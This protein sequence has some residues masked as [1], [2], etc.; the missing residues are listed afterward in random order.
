MRIEDY[1]DIWANKLRWELSSVPPHNVAGRIRDFVSRT[2]PGTWTAA[3]KASATAELQTRFAPKGAP[4]HGTNPRTPPN[5][6]LHTSPFRFV[7]IPSNVALA[8]DTAC[9]AP[10]A[11]GPYVHTPDNAKPLKDGYSG[12]LTVRW[13][14]ETPILIGVA[15][16]PG[17]AA[18]DEPMQLGGQYVIPGA[19]LRGMVRSTME[20]V[21]RARLTQVNTHHAY[22]LRDFT[23]SRYRER[24]AASALRAGWLEKTDEGYQLTP[25]DMRIVK[26]RDVLPLLPNWPH[27]AEKIGEQHRLW[28]RSSLRDKYSAAGM[29]AAGAG[30]PTRFACNDFWNDFIDV[31]STDPNALPRVRPLPVGTVAAGAL[32]GTLVFS[33]ALPNFSKTAAVLDQEDLVPTL[34]NAKKYECVFFDG[35]DRVAVPLR[36]ETMSRFEL[37]NC[38]PSRRGRQPAGSYEVLAPTLR[39][40]R[41]IPVFY[42]GDLGGNQHSL[43]IGLT[44]LF[45]IG[46]DYSVGDKLAKEREHAPDPAKPDLVEALFGH[47]FEPFDLGKLPDDAPKGLAR[48]GRIAFGFARLVNPRDSETSATPLNTLMMAP[49]ASFAPFYLKG[50]YK[51]WSDPDARLAGRKRYFPRFA[52]TAIPTASAS[53]ET[54]LRATAQLGNAQ[55]S[56]DTLSRLRLLKPRDARKP[57]I[58]EGTIRLHNVLAK[59]IG[60]LLWVL[61]HGG[62]PAKPYRHMIGRAKPFGAGQT[63]VQSVTLDLVRNDGN[64][65]A[66]VSP[67]AS[68]TAWELPAAG[69]EGWTT[70]GAQSLTPFLRAFE[71]HMKTAAIEPSWPLVIE[72]QELLACS[73][74]GHLSAALPGAPAYPVLGD[75]ATIRKTT[76]HTS[77]EAPPTAS[78]NDRF[79]TIPA[80]APADIRLPYQTPTASGI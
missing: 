19:T 64:A 75:F 31:P 9:I 72:I 16:G 33:D 59:E 8:P 34:G 21:S 77:S 15:D 11:F 20:I 6:A 38:V 79:L 35:D 62:D 5:A 63:R 44:R 80:I 1:A 27:A 48:K 17:A 37:M 28:L 39:A 49:R 76:K 46:H 47:V 2:A 30:G 54:A 53:V 68:E 57:L 60:A 78:V 41:R 74:P 67:T 56:P 70:P 29:I 50:R 73:K 69:S 65:I 42:T 40:Q 25:C 58:F 3:Q 71:Q 51:D 43:E 52:E 7:T 13:A 10:G 12:D 61:T 4:G 23:H 22:P 32:S 66:Q 45:K 36:R 14:V 55:P 18:V 24:T 26:I